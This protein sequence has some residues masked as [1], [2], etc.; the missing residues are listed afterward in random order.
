MNNSNTVY[1]LKNKNNDTS[2]PST[3]ESIH[4]SIEGAMKDAAEYVKR[5]NGKEVVV[6]LNGEL[7]E[8]D[9]R[10]LKYCG[11]H[12]V[13][14]IHYKSNYGSYR[15]AMYVQKVEVLP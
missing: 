11:G 13:P 4:Y 5:V 15:C 9:G 12:K 14:A 3:I 1:F 7:E 2:E 10:S 6:D 8:Y